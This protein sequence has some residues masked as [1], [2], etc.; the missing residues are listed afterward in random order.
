MAGRK[1]KYE[2]ER[3]EKLL[4]AIR[5]GSTYQHACNYAGIDTDTFANWRAKY[6]D[7]SDQVKQA[8]GSALVGWLAKIEAAANDGNWQAAAWKA[9]RRYP[10]EYG[11]RVITQQVQGRIIVDLDADANDTAK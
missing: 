8:E 10:D 5:L 11:R 3:V 6:P 4:E 9:E 1:S 7:F 2:P